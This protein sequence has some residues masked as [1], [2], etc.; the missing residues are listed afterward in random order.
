MV[1]NLD[2]AYLAVVA[3]EGF[4]TLRDSL[5]ARITAVGTPLR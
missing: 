5:Y 4:I 3:G 2:R 1:E